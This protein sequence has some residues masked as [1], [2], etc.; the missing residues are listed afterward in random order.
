[1]HQGSVSQPYARRVS[2]SEGNREKSLSISMDWR[3]RM[4]MEKKVFK[5]TMIIVE[6]D[7]DVVGGECTKD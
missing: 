7:K 3:N 5:M 6:K 1:M 4:Q 2:L